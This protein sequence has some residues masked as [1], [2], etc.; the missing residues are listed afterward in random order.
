MVLNSALY[1]VLFGEQAGDIAAPDE[2]GFK[3]VALIF[4]PTIL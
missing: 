3:A 2:S 4:V 1:W